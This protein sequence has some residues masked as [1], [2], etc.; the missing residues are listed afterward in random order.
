MNRIKNEITHFKKIAADVEEIW[1]WS[2]PAGKIRAQRRANYLLQLGQFEAKDPILEIGCGTGLFTE[3]IGHRIKGTLFAIDISEDL[4]AL[5]KKRG[6]DRVIF[7]PG[8]AMALAFDDN[9]FE[10]VYGNSIL[11]HLEMDVALKEIFR[12]LKKGGRAVFAEPNMLNPQ[13]LIQKNVPFVKKYMGDSPDETAIV[14]WKLAKMMRR[15]GF[16]QVTIFPYDFLHPAT[17]HF[18]IGLV[19][20]L[21]VTLENIPLLKEIAG[22]VMIV[23]EK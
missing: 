13:I 5:A 21:G 15:I 19:Q 23:G 22:S 2:T 11:H 16:K 9:Y 10:A 1:G 14:R 7:Q 3:K 6:L 8:N 17:P 12:V 20:K 4:L 18:L